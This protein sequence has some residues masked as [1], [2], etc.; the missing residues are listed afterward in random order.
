MRPAAGPP[1]LGVTS[2][3][4]GHCFHGQG[5]QAE[6]VFQKQ[7]VDILQWHVALWWE[8]RCWGVLRI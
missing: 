6:V 7:G 1:H 5:S 4:L 3:L 8:S 2:F